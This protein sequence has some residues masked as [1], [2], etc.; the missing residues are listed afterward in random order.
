M[1][2]S[3]FNQL[4]ERL[5]REEILYCHWKSNIDL[6]ETIEGNLDIDLLVS[7]Q[8]LARTTEILMQLGFKL[9]VPRWGSNP[10]GVFHYYGYDPNKRDFVHL[11]MFTRVLTGESFL[12][13]H[14]LPFEEMLTK[15]VSF[16]NGLKVASKEAELVLFVLRSYIKY[17]SLLDA[18]RL[19]KDQSKLIKEAQW[20]QMGSDMQL[21][22]S[23]LEKHC[24]TISEDLFVDCLKSLQTKTPYPKLWKRSVL[25]RRRLRIYRKYTFAKMLAGYFEMFSGIVVKKVR[26]QKGSKVFS[27]GGTVI[28]IV[29]ADATGK[30]TMVSEASR[31]LRKNFVLTTIHAGKPPSTLITFPIN[32][33]LAIFK[34]IYKRGKSED[35]NGD[36]LSPPNTNE[37]G[38]EQKGGY[39]LVYAIR[40]LVLAWDRRS[41]LVKARRA[42]ANG[43]IVVCDRYPTI[44]VGMMDSPRLQDNTEHK[45][46][47]QSIYNWLARM[48]KNQYKQIAPPDI[49]LRFNVS[50]EVARQRNA[51]REIVDDDIYLQNRHQQ[52]T[53]WF[54]PGTRVIQDINTDSSLADTLST[55]KQ[56]IWRSL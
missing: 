23:L 45:G 17:G 56:T 47:V 15:N 19:L 39:S 3:L 44:S 25:I 28:S 32:L 16:V 26:K 18:I 40:A 6:A 53:E 35:R 21:V 27:S 20:L 36:R 37:V 5:N 42:I 10:P 2:Q 14:L 29:G 12:K 9:A 30:S 43:E 50:L 46:I 8:S 38:D 4:I 54:M 51:A 11:H 34:G 41:L 22:L 13:S 52:A 1:S 24:P 7:S 55:V 48:E 33:L 31:W 49:V